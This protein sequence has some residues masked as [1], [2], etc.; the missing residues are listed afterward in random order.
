M[1]HCEVVASHTCRNNVGQYVVDSRNV[2]LVSETLD[3]G[4][5]RSWWLLLN[6]GCTSFVSLAV[7][8]RAWEVSELTESEDITSKS[9][10]GGVGSGSSPFGNRSDELS[11]E[12]LSRTGNVAT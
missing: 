5:A 4:V 10:F 3:D 7:A 9:T 8:E 1:T 2:I 6:E 12:L 11:L